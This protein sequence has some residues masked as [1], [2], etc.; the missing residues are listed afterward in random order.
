MLD[1][2][3]AD[4]DTFHH[5]DCGAAMNPPCDGCAARVAASGNA[6]GDALRQFL[7]GGA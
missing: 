2:R 5:I 7:T 3:R 6:T 4:L 1:T